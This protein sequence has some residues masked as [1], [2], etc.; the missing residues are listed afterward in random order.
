MARHSIYILPAFFIILLWLD[1]GHASAQTLQWAKSAAGG[2]DDHGFR[3]AGDPQGNCIIA[4][5]SEGFCHFDNLIMHSYGCTD[6]FLAKYDGSGQAAW[7]RHFGTMICDYAHA[8]CTD[9]DANVYVAADMIYGAR[10][11]SAFTDSLGDHDIVLAK[12]DPNGNFLW[13]KSFGGPGPDLCGYDMQYH[14]GS[15]YLMGEFYDTVAFDSIVLVPT[16]RRDGFVMK[17]DTAGAVQW[18]RQGSCTHDFEMQSLSISPAGDIYIAA[19]FRGY[20]YFG[21]FGIQAT[22]PIPH[23]IARLDTDGYVRWVKQF[24]GRRFTEHTRIAA[25]HSGDFFIASETYENLEIDS[26]LFPNDGMSW[27][28]RMDS[29]GNLKWLSRAK[30]TR[31][32]RPLALV[33]DAH[34]NAYVSGDFQDTAIIGNVLLLAP[35]QNSNTFVAHYADDGSLVSAFPLKSNWYNAPGDLY[36]EG[37]TALYITGHYYD[38]IY[39]G[40]QMLL[41]LGRW[42]IYLAKFITA[43]VVGLPDAHIPDPLYLYPNPAQTQFTL[44]DARMRKGDV[45]SLY[46]SD[47]RLVRRIVMQGPV[48]EITVEDL[49]RGMYCCRVDI[50][51]GSALTG[52]VLLK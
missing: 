19:R 39:V 31:Y 16:G 43:A 29:A 35:R 28:A 14:D 49:P 10:F 36:L 5:H 12:Y 34:D 1:P 40:S 23:L 24:S 45:L 2:W 27:L 8:V 47:G 13:V 48:Q 4:G 44:K 26:M 41:G 15:L 38:S 25:S 18:V 46:H 17:V 7:V 52:K 20:A 50:R 32:I 51:R 22:T 3:L 21:P 9:P 37:D 6:G 33:V 30:S 11:D 42:D